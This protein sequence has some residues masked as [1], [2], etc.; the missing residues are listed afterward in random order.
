MHRARLSKARRDK[1]SSGRTRR[2]NRLHRFGGQASSRRDLRRP[3]R[4][5]SRLRIHPP[6]SQR[7][8]PRLRNDIDAN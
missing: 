5:G 2:R 4:N 1:H 6:Q 8:H 7:A 3:L